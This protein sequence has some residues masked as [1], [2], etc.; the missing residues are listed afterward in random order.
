MLCM[1]YMVALD[2]GGREG[3]L[4]EG[5]KNGREGGRDEE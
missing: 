5:R 4:E 2:H 3:G 1:V